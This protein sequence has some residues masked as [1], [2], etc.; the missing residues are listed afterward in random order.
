MKEGTYVD[1]GCRDDDT[2][3]ELLQSYEKDVQLVRQELHEED[4]SKDTWLSQLFCRQAPI[5][6]RF[7]TEGAGSEHS[8]DEPDPQRHVIFAVHPGA[9]LLV[10]LTLLRLAWADT[11]SSRSQYISGHRDIVT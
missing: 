8:E 7:R 2:S 4:R 9:G 1:E 5:S 3:A 10:P 11:V 6:R